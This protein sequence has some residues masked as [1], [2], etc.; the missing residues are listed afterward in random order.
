MQAVLLKFKVN[1][2]ES[3]QT[4]RSDMFFKLFLQV[5]LN[6][7]SEQSYKMYRPHKDLKYIQDSL[8]DH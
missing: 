1:S 4:L 3:N 8:E 6:T 2:F 7:D 5:H